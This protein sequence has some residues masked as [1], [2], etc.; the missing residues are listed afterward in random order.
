MNYLNIVAR[1]SAALFITAGLLF[2]Q[3]AFAD[4]VTVE[5]NV[6][7]FVRAETASQIDRFLKMFVGG[8]VNTWAHFRAPTAIDEQVVIR[9]NRDTLYSA[10]LIDIS[11]GATLTIPETGDRYLS[12]MIVNEDHYIN[13]V[14][15]DAGTYELTMDEFHTPY[16]M[17]SART[18][19]DSSDPVDIEK[20]N[21]LQDQMMVKA[22][23]AR[24][25][26]HPNYDPASYKTTYNALLELSRGLPDAKRMFGNKE[27]V[28]EVRHLI[29]AAFG[30][31]GLPEYEA[32]Y[33]NVEPSLPVGAY[34][35]KVGNV[36][37]DAFWSISLYNKDGFFEENEYDAYS[38]NNIS[39]TPNMDGSFIIH[40][41]GDSESVNYLPIMDGWNYIVRLYQ[42]RKEILDGTWTFPTVQEVK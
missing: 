5:V 39:G 12:I 21:A 18:L 22:A 28:G 40:F 13:K 42:P 7:N 8:K 2:S 26:T 33:L 14:Y 30:W 25:Y 41:G 34:E 32:S 19:V 24:P 37:V 17:A 31:G 35:I 6:D 20:V 11:K 23:S 38:V 1:I 16:V 29:G 4:D 15:H 9:M 36:P 10:I 3:L 27:E